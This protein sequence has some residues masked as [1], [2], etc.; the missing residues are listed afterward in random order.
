MQK[1]YFF[2]F[3]LG[4]FTISQYFEKSKTETIGQF[5]FHFSL[6]NLLLHKSLGPYIFFKAEHKE[7][8]ETIQDF[9]YLI[10]FCP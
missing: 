2:W 3:L 1:K 9:T 5:F 10:M 6:L 8:I 7:I 4:D